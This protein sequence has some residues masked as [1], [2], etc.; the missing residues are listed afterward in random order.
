MA[1][2]T[3]VSRFPSTSPLP[4]V[5]PSLASLEQLYFPN[6]IVMSDIVPSLLTDVVVAG[7]IHITIKGMLRMI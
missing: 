4:Y 3:A 5:C 1:C 2:M 6:G 7:G